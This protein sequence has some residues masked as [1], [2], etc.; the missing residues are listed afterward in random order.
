MPLSAAEK[1]RRYRERIRNDPQRRA[2]E[3]RKDRERWHKRK[4]LIANISDKEKRAQRKLWRTNKQKL[5]ERHK[6]VYVDTPP[7]TPSTSEDPA[8]PSYSR[9]KQMGRKVLRRDRARCYKRLQALEKKLKQKEAAVNRYKQRIHRL[10][11]KTESPRSKTRKLLR[12]LIVSEKVKKTL[13]FHHTLLAQIKRNYDKTRNERKK[14]LFRKFLCGKIVKRYKM[15]TI[16]RETFKI[17]TQGWNNTKEERKKPCTGASRLKKCVVDLFCRD[18]ISRITTGKKQTVTR[19]KQKEQ[20][21]L[22]LDTMKNLHIKYLAENSN[23]TLSYCSVHKT[24]T[25]LCGETNCE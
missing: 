13:D 6:R 3:L 21:R 16:T 1:Q 4:V 25:I 15:Q 14:R 23:H 18:D 11:K 9:Q 24:E 8:S 22:L 2:E 10:Q 19:N 20:K 5:R 12:N 7:D 17:S